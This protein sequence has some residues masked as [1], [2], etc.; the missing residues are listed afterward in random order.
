MNRTIVIKI[1]IATL[2]D[3]QHL[4]DKSKLDRLALLVANLHNSGKKV[5]IVSS[6]AIALGMRKLGI[7]TQPDSSIHKQAMAAIGQ[8]ELIKTYQM[9]L[10]E[11]NQTV[12]QVL[13]TKDV[14]ENVERGANATNT[15][16]ALL[17]MN[18][19]PIV[20]ENDAISTDDIL[21]EDNYPLALSVARLSNASMMLIKIDNDSRYILLSRG[22]NKYYDLEE[23]DVFQSVEELTHCGHEELATGTFPTSFSQLNDYVK[24]Y[25][26]T[27]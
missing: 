21:L 24:N 22:G 13:M 25:Y 7:K 14:T 1:E 8:A 11:Y 15:F 3:A 4:V 19:I 12:A 20:N 16:R 18:I 10:G 6:G 5:I 23:K 2:C 27:I 17:D 9:H 26:K